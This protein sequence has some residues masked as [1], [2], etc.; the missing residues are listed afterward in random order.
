MRRV[1]RE[2]EWMEKE[3]NEVD[4][5]TDGREGR[6]DART[7]GRFGLWLPFMVVSGAG[8]GSAALVP[9]CI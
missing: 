7:H 2:I 8:G 6:A 5:R 1:Q 9:L 4:T 3:E